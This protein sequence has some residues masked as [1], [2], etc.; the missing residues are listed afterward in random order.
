MTANETGLSLPEHWF[1]E[2]RT[3]LCQ[4]NSGTFLQYLY[5]N[6]KGHFNV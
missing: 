6:Y 2:K 4:L 5:L 3:S 1:P